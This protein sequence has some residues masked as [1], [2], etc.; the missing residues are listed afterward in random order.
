V[1]SRQYPG[2]IDEGVTQLWVAELLIRDGEAQL[3][4]KR[5]V[6]EATWPECWLEAQDFRNQDREL[7]FSCYQPDNNAE[8]MGVELSTGTVV[9]Y[10]NSPEVYDEPEGI[11]P[12]G[13][14]TLV[15]SDLQNDKG[16]H[17]IDIWKLRLDGG[18]KSYE[19][20]T[21]FSDYPG[22]KASNPVVSPDGTRMAFQLARS[23][24]EPGVGYGILIMKFGSEAGSK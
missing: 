14:S 9:N 12:D 22:Y 15:E 16:D 11:F 7:I 8:V 6:H 4:Q 5:K 2:E 10:T 20:L 21:H 3:E 17:F 1:S 18:G 24:D 19:R 13:I 23:S